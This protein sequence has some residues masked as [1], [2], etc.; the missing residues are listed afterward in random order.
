MRI[1]PLLPLIAAP[2]FAAGSP[3]APW[4]GELRLALHSE[5]RTLNPAMADDEASETIRYLT[6]GVLVRVNRLTQQPEPALAVSWKILDSG[7]TIR[8][9]LRE[10]VCFSDGTPFTADD[11]VY[12]METLMDPALHSPVGDS[13]R[14][15]PGAVRAAAEGPYAVTIRFPA[16]LAGGV[17]LFDQAAI[18]SRRSPL[19]EVAVL[20]PFRVADRRPGAYLRLERNPNYWKTQSGRRLPYLDSIRLEVQQNRDAELLR[21]RR[22]DLHIISALDADQ[23]EA[24]AR[25]RADWARDAGPALENEFVWFNMAPSA[26]LPDHKKAWFASRNFRRA[27]SHAIRRDDLCRVVYHGHAAPGVGPFPPAN[28]FWFNRKLKPHAFDLA[29]ARRLLSEA[30]FRLEGGRLR[31]RAGN[32]VEFSLIMNAGNKGRERMASMIQQDLAALNV[33]LNVV[34]LDFPSLLERIGKTMQYEA[35]LLGFN[36]VDA[37]PDGQMNLWLSSSTNH[38]WNPRQATPA[39]PWEAEIDRLMKAQASDPQ[40]S[41]RKALFDRV[42]EIVWDQAPLLYLLNRDALVAVSPAL[43]NVKPSVFYP[44]VLWNIDEIY[45]ARKP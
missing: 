35:C 17:R 25:E 37:D 2:L 41:R 7:K 43:G 6:G 27:I 14:T 18:V 1:L 22:G 39:T 38:P 3:T 32:G 28:Q 20:G 15:G 19:K 5:P 24:L 40:P 4:G 31:D 34:T 33:R 30:G 23:F 44:R 21:F 16:P 45:L 42:Q 9:R 26:P 29:L 8:F 12:T 11:V 13:F 36:N 10:N